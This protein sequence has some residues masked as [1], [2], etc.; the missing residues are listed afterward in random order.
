MDS[1]GLCQPSSAILLVSVAGAL[2]NLLAGRMYSVAWWAMVGVFGTGVFQGLCYGGLEPLA[3]ILM[4]I[5]VLIVCFFLAVALF[6]SRMRIDNVIEV[7]CGRCG[8]RPCGCTKPKPRCNRTRCDACSGCGCNQCLLSQEPPTVE[9]YETQPI[10]ASATMTGCPQCAGR[11]CP[12]C[13]FTKDSWAALEKA[14]ATEGFHPGTEVNDPVSFCEGGICGSHAGCRGAGC[15]YCWY[16][17]Q[18]CADCGGR[19]CPSCDRRQAR[20]T[21]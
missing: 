5:P 19:G 12:Y 1:L 4:S 3:W 16:R 18:V 20:A 6:A 15:P 11:G 2:Y 10:A 8:R 14:K 9:N 7:P 21:Y 13:P 17:Q